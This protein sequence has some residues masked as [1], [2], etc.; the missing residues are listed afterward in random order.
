M[1]AKRCIAI[2]VSL[3]GLPSINSNV[4][5]ATPSPRTSEWGAYARRAG[6]EVGVDLS[7]NPPA[8]DF[9]SLKPVATILLR[10]C[11]KPWASEWVRRK[12]GA[13][14]IEE[15]YFWHF[16]GEYGRTKSSRTK[17]RPARL[18][19]QSIE[20]KTCSL[21]F[22]SG[23]KTPQRFSVMWSPSILL[24]KQVLWLLIS[25]RHESAK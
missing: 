8:K 11:R 20:S 24:K 25:G 17:Y 6:C 1:E 13:R 16:I 12:H 3:N 18:P 9:V 19:L 15:I 7:G 10:A 23:P 2:R 21:S 14:A 5:L 4:Y 22:R